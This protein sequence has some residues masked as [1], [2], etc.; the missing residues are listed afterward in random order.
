MRISSLSVEN[1]RAIKSY[2]INFDSHAV[3]IGSNNAGKST[4]LKA[5]DLFFDNA[6]KVSI[7]DFH[8]HR[9]DSPISISVTFTE[10]TPEERDLFASNLIENALCITRELIFGNPKES[11]TFFVHGL[12]NPD[13]SD[14]RNDP[15]KSTKT[16]KYKALRQTERYAEL[17]QISKADDIDSHL[18]AWESQ[19]PAELKS[20]KLATFR[21][22]K[23]VAVG[24]LKKKTDYVLVP[25]VR[26]AAQDVGSSKGSP[27]KQLID[28]VARQTIENTDDFKA[29][30]ATANAE[31]KRLTDPAKVGALQNISNS[32]S[33]SLQKFYSDAEL[34][35]SWDPVE[36]IPIAFP[37]SKI[38]VKNGGHTSPVEFVGH[39]LQRAIIITI[40]DFLARQKAVNNDES[41]TEPQSDLII[42]IEEPEIYQHP[43]K[44]RH[45]AR[46]LASLA[47]SFN[48]KTGIRLQIIL[49]THSPLFVNL[50]KFHEVRIIRRRWENG[51]AEMVLSQLT[52]K[53]CSTALAK[54]IEAPQPMSD[55]SFAAKLHIFSADMSE[56]FFA[57]KVVLVEGVSDRAI[58]EAAYRQKERSPI[59]EGIAIISCDGK[60]KIDKPAYIFHRLQIP[61]FVLMDN[62]QSSTK[63]ND[64]K[65]EVKYNRLVQTICDVPDAEIIDW[66]SSCK[67]R[68]AAWD[69]NLEAYLKKRGGDEY[70]AAKTKVMDYFD[71]S[72]DD[73]VKSPTVASALL[74]HMYAAGITFPEIEDVITAVDGL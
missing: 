9:S 63:A 42:G 35:A 38:D 33:D 59:E 74:T 44:Q 46:V 40:L 17:P 68:F 39:G 18:E 7:D 58:L 26:E 4:F 55:A 6:P 28:T 15:S 61:T 65:N 12:A 69:C 64:V 1:F 73:C 32:L 54:L 43:T 41:F 30:V 60:K 49:V 56:G 52:L 14:C 47:D 2:K 37:S 62:D 70:E 29:L 19:H 24:Q 5:L 11:G 25:A 72:G 36:Q 22:F 67:A 20:V 51:S 10:L 23:N 27:A 13:F 8:H 50:P 66:P 16:E 48:K 57:N 34:I 71:V 53:E 45:I 31:I 3:L 21:G